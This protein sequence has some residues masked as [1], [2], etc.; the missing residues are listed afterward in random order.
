M[1][2]G[3]PITNCAVKRKGVEFCWEC[4]ENGT[5]EKWAKHLKLGRQYDSFKCYQ[6]LERDVAFIREKGVARFEKEQRAREQL[7]TEMLDG[8]NDGRSKTYYCIAVTVMEP[9]EL[10]KA[11]DKAEKTAEGLDP[12]GK[13]RLLH[14]ILD[15]IAARQG[16][17]LKLRK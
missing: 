17:L 15:G 10:R 12:K 16:Y 6:T 8:F 1:G 14:G 9:G 11:L 4:E 5:C 7:L 13:A 2:A 3:C